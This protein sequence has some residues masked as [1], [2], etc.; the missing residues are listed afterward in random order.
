MFKDVGQRQFDLLLIFL[1]CWSA[2]IWWH[3]RL[4][5]K[6][7]F[8]DGFWW[9]WW[10]NWQLRRAECFCQLPVLWCFV[11]E[12]ERRAINPS[13]P[14]VLGLWR[15]GLGSRNKSQTEHW[16]ALPPFFFHWR[17]HG[18]DEFVWSWGEKLRPRIAWTRFNCNWDQMNWRQTVT[19]DQL[20]LFV[21]PS[22]NEFYGQFVCLFCPK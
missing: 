22:L 20:D 7:S 9:L 1:F 15:V 21:K 14:S 12:A 16:V 10:V 5:G 13:P 18:Q 19:R 8:A 3:N 11:V 2:S 4:M 6:V 17:T